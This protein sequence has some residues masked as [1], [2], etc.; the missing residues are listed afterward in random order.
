VGIVGDMRRT[1]Y[2]HEPRPETFLPQDQDP[3]NTLTIVARTEGEPAQ[4]GPALRDAIWSV[5]KDQSVSDL[6]TMDVMLTE[7]TA[8][9]RFNTILLGIFAT[10]ALVLAAVG[11]YGVMS[12]S[13]M[14]RM[15]ELGVRIALG[16]SSGDVLR[17]VAG[18]AMG[19]ALAGI[20]AGLVAALLLTRLMTSLLYGVTATDPVTFVLISG[21]LTAVAL[22]A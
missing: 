3:D 20:G 12:Y 2:D 16:A 10:L 9:H 14:Q 17:L 15:H 5:D 1:G 8:Q 22:A 19:L 4:L 21:L 18:H 7:M 6:K 11:I 13:V